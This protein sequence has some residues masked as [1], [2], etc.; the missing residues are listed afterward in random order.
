M[1][2]VKTGCR[3]PVTGCRLFRQNCHPDESQDP[4]PRSIV[5][6]AKAGT[7]SHEA[8]YAMEPVPAFAGMTSVPAGLSADLTGNRQPKKTGLHFCNPV[9]LISLGY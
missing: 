9:F 4:L 8:R 7:A 3:L 5:I 1:L 6:P 2:P